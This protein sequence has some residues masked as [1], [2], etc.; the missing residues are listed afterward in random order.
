MP[1]P[2]QMLLSL[3]IRE[4]MLCSR[5]SSLGTLE[6]DLNLQVCLTVLHSYSFLV[7]TL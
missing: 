1:I 4:E 6:P 3:M 7:C 5:S 2:S